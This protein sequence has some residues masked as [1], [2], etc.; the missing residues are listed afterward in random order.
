MTIGWSTTNL[1]SSASITAATA[2]SD[3][4]AANIV[5]NRIR[6]TYRSTDDDDE[7]VK[8]DLGSDQ[9]VDIFTVFQNNITTSPTTFKILGHAS[10][11]GNNL[12]DWVGS[13]TYEAS[14]SYDGKVAIVYPDQSLRWWMIGVDDASNPA[15]YIELGLA[16]AGALTNTT[17]NFNEYF[18]DFEVDPSR[19]SFSEGQNPYTVDK[20]SN[21]YK[22]YD[23]QFTDIES[24]DIA[25]LR[26]LFRTV[27][28]GTAFVLS[29]DTN[30]SVELTRFGLLVDGLRFSFQ[31]NQR[32]TAA[33][34]FREIN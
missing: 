21:R 28:I 18:D 9:Q 10:D 4:P 16:W 20:L 29:L 8:F 23:I 6:N 3:F 25:L 30:D 19:V 5:D 14:L 17:H 26:T 7:W 15:G 34:P 12:S 32:A 22:Q 27:G 24:A 11:L 1:L 33:L 31:E 2:D 13:A